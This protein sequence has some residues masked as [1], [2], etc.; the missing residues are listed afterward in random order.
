MSSSS[1]VDAVASVTTRLG[2]KPRAARDPREEARKEQ[3]QGVDVYD[4]ACGDLE[5]MILNQQQ[6]LGGT[7]TEP[8]H[9]FELPAAATAG[10]EAASGLRAAAAGKGTMVGCGSNNNNNRPSNS[11]PLFAGVSDLPS[12]V[13]STPTTPLGVAR[14][15]PVASLSYA[16]SDKGMG[17]M[18]R[19]KSAGVDAAV[20]TSEPLLG[21]SLQGDDSLVN[22][23]TLPPARPVGLAFREA[24]AA[25]ACPERMQAAAAV[26][27]GAGWSSKQPGE[28]YCLG[29][30][31]TCG[32]SVLIGTMPSGASCNTHE[33]HNREQSQ[34][35]QQ[36]HSPAAQPLFRFGVN[37][38][39]QGVA[40]CSPSGQLWVSHQV[41]QQRQEQDGNVYA[42]YCLASALSSIELMGGRVRFG[43]QSPSQP[44]GAFE[45]EVAGDLVSRGVVAVTIVIRLNIV[46]VYE[47]PSF[48]LANY[49]HLLP[50]DCDIYGF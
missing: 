21:A 33:Y 9:L 6:Q 24:A 12:S 41:Q 29:L 46:L 17:C 18:L 3:Q 23:G 42:S 35:Q 45:M 36:Q 13:L 10:R 1:K 28:Y 15:I 8:P 16:D 30:E 48:L 25:A 14:S 20:V 50:W 27:A 40:G 26:V 7:Q 19:V 2:T 43:L 34:Q 5:A 32:D 49:G 38:D 47:V 11:R 31:D 22:F 4:A 37:P 39:L 44:G